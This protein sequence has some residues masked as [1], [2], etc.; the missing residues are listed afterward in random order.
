MIPLLTPRLRLRPLT[1]DDLRALHALVGDDETMRFI[2]G[3]GN[4]PLQTR[5]RLALD[6]RLHAEFGFG[7]CLAEWRE[8][9]EVVGRAGIV[10]H[11]T[12]TG[13]E[14]ELA[15]LVARGWRGRGLATEAGAALIEFARREL[16][17][18]RLYAE[19]HPDNAGSIRVMEKLGMVPVGPRG[20]DAVYEFR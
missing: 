19:A 9:G 15:W 17:L 8:T 5:A 11:P 1:L 7:L 2:T 14:G 13:V 18:N 4:T 12:A 20:R 3:V 10:P 6:V 16:E